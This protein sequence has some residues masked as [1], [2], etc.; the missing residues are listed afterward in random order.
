ML[1]FT[2]KQ[3]QFCFINLQPLYAQY[4]QYLGKATIIQISDALWSCVKNKVYAKY[5][6]FSPLDP[7]SFLL[8]PTLCPEK[9]T[10]KEYIGKVPMPLWLFK[11][12]IQWQALV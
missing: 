3:L 12:F 4:I 7:I 2:S 1:T 11:W 6:L 9:L 5:L 8:L 10:Y